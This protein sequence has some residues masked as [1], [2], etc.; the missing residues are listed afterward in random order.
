MI[1]R[2]AVA[3]SDRRKQAN[4][5]RHGP[6]SDHRPAEPSAAHIG[7]HFKQDTT[8]NQQDTNNTEYDS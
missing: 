5:E 4:Q 7:E 3:L 1:D 8:R 6:H 2:S